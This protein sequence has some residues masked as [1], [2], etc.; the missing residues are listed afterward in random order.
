MANELRFATNSAERM[1]ISADGYVTIFNQPRASVYRTTTQ[2]LTDAADTTIGFNAETTDIGAMHDNATNNSRI[3][4]PTGGDG[5]Y[6]L[7]TGIECAANATGLRQIQFL[8][9]GATVLGYDNRLSVGASVPTR[10]TL[11]AQADLVATD[12]VEVRVYQDSGGALNTGS[13]ATTVWFAA[14]K[15]T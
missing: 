6:V 5:T 12:Y 11:V 9:N 13:G 15:V 7:S 10:V 14:V 8:K 4:I 1:R 2:S 3:T